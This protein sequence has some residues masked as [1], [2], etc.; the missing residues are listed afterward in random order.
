LMSLLESTKSFNVLSSPK[1]LSI[2]NPIDPPLVFVGQQIPYADSAQFDDQGDDDPTNNRLVINYNRTFVGNMLPVIPFILNDDHI[3]LELA[4]QII[5]PGERLPVEI[6]GEVTTGAEIPNVGP[7]L[8]NQQYLRTSIRMKN[9]TTVV[10][11]GLITEREN[12]TQDKVPILSKIPLLG[13]MFIDRRIEKQKSSILF[14]ITA[15][16]IEPSL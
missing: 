12:E 10:L 2:A 14:F 1:V 15:R 9:G 3:Y 11:G 7:L 5:E 4:P 16:I 8:L 13:N 6:T